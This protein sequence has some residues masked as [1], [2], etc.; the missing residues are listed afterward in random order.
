LRAVFSNDLSQPPLQFQLV[1]FV[2]VNVARFDFLKYAGHHPELRKP[3]LDFLSR[4]DLVI[5]QPNNRLYKSPFLLS[6]VR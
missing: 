5:C 2:C 6:D 3:M 1:A 4:A